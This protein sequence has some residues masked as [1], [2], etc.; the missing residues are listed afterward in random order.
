MRRTFTCILCPNGC[1]IVSETDGRELLSIRGCGCDKGRE[2]VEQELSSPMRTISSLVRVWGGTQPLA[3]VR[4]SEPV[5]RERIFDVMAEIKKL[6]LS[7]PVHIGQ[8]TLPDILGLGSDV[9]VTKNV[10]REK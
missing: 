6:T 2:Y 7:A 5:P 1:E 4:L 10:G 9:I 3:S 8:V